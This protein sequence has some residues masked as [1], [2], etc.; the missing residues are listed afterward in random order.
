MSGMGTITSLDLETF[1][2]TQAPLVDVRSP[3]EFRQ[4]HW[5]AAINIPLFSD[6]QRADVGLTYKTV[7]RE[8][9]IQLG[10][11]HVGPRLASLADAL[12]EAAGSGSMLRLS[13]W[14]GGLRSS[15]VAWLAQ[16]IGLTPFLL[17]GG[18]KCYRR[19][20]LQQFDRP[21]P[22][23]LLGGRTGTGKTDLLLELQRRRV[24]VV[25]L[26]GLAHHRGSS[27]GGLGLPEQPSTEHFENRLAEALDQHRQGGAEQIWLEAESAQVGRCRIPRALFEQMQ[28]APVL[29]IRRSLEERIEQLVKVYAP[30]GAAPLRAATERIS[31]RLGPQRTLES[32]TAI[33]RCD[34]H[35]ACRSMLEYYD[36]CYD[37]ELARAVERHQIDLHGLQVD[38]AAEALI[39]Q[40]WIRSPGALP[41]ETSSR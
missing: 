27:F 9:A 34:W 29:E 37:H 3:S 15:S 22:L 28:A 41:S 24:A 21:W 36:R 1:R 32:L 35:S 13:C 23:R 8:A 6:A 7:G 40:E 11:K 25:D 12:Q 33:D 18:Y 30:L 4:G 20:V 2:R 19:W 31:R 10:L 38:Q 26:E 14:R 17:T 16:L 5:P 39:R